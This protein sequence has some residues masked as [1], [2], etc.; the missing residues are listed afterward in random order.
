MTDTPIL[1]ELVDRDGRTLSTSEKIAAHRPPG[2][3]HRAFSVFLF[4]ADGRMLLQRRARGKYHW[5][6]VWSNACCGHPLPGEPPFLAAARR[7]AEEL[8]AAP[9]SLSAVGTV[10]YVFTDTGTGLVE[11]EFNHLFAGRIGA[12]VRPDPAEVGETVL[13]APD[14]L[15]ALRAAEPFSAWFGT[16]LEAAA[17]GIRGLVPEGGW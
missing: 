1:V 12:D 11:R 3:L 9:E 14:G 2:A 5:P 6:G 15:A 7:T 8:G 17:P 13:V 16:V 4:S 10:D